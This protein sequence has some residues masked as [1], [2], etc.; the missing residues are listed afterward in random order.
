[1]VVANQDK[2]DSM[3][4][5]K[6]LHNLVGSEHYKSGDLLA[7]KEDEHCSLEEGKE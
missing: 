6:H 1:M 4:A 3:M 7:Q 5:E 2:Q